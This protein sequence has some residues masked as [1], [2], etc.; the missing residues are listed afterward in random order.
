[1]TLVYRLPGPSRITS[2][3]RM[4]SRAAGSA[5][6]CSGS[7]RT[8]WMR[9]FCSFLAAKILDSPRT[10]EPLSKM[11]SSCTSAL[12]TGRMRPVMASTWLIRATAWSKESEMP[13]SAA[14][15]R[16]PNACP[17]SRPSGKR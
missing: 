12:V 13:S 17:A 8:W 14:S 3:P 15:S 4:A 10:L 7:S 9:Q 2:A 16:L 5:G 6:A 11:A 1:M